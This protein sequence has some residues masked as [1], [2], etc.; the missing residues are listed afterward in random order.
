MGGLACVTGDGTPNPDAICTPGQTRE[1]NCFHDGGV[2][3]QEC[4]SEGVAFTQCSA[5]QPRA[6]S[7]SASRSPS[8]AGTA[9]SSLGQASSGQGNASSAVDTCAERNKLI[10]LVDENHL[11]SSFNPATLAFVD[12]GTLNCPNAAGFG[13]FS[14]GVERT[15]TAWVLYNSGQLY[16]VDT[17]NA[18][19]VTSGFVPEQ[20]GM[21]LFGMGFVS[22][23]AG[24]FAETLHV[25]GGPETMDFD[26]DRTLGRISLPGLVF[27]GTGTV[28]GSPELTGNRDGEL[29]GFFPSQFSPRAARLNKVTGAEVETWELPT[30]AGVPRAWAFAF[31][32]GSFYLF[33]KRDTDVSTRVYRLDV[34]N[35]QPSVSTVI[36]NTNRS[37]V[38]AGV[39]TC[40]PLR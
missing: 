28:Q 33:L 19:C 20:D 27:T 7:T 8:S 18:A 30:L 25:A 1:C 31:W 6:A 38:G 40:A 9:T 36:S 15:G 16:R 13:T 32:G 17:T 2:G 12:V 24:S 29:F 37:I 26:G 4:T 10:Y 11:L 5:C 22:N 39:S 21:K 23:T 3:F 34:T 14:M 35:G